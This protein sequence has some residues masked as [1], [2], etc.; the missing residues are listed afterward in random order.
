MLDGIA[1]QYAIIAFQ[2][3]DRW[4]FLSAEGCAVQAARSGWRLFT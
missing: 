3:G 1:T 2:S 4:F